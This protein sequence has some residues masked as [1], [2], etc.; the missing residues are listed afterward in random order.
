MK[1]QITFLAFAATTL[2][3]AGCQDDT[4]V[5][6]ADL[7]P[8][9]STA[10]GQ[11]SGRA[12][13]ADHFI[14][15]YAGREVPAAAADLISAKGGQ[16]ARAWDGMGFA[17]ITEI[18]DDD[19]RE[20]LTVPG[21]TG[22]SRDVR[23]RWIPEVTGPQVRTLK[24]PGPKSHDPTDA[25]FFDAFQ[26]NMRQVEAD[27]AWGAGFEASPDV[28]VAV[29]DTGV[30]PDHIDLQGRVDLN[31]SR[32]VLID[33]FC[34]DF[35]DVPDRETFLDFNFHGTHVSGIVTTNGIGVAGVAPHAT[36]VAVKV[37]ACDGF[38]FFSQ[39]IDGILYAASIPVDV[40]N[41]SLG[42]FL[43]EEFEEEFEFESEFEEFEEEFEF[44]DQVLIQAF[45]AATTAAGDAGAYVVASAGND[46][47]DLDDL[48]F[49][50]ESESQFNG[51]ESQLTT[52]F[53]LK[54]VPAQS[55]GVAAIS[56]TGPIGQT[57][58][59]RLASY[60]NFGDGEISLAAPGGDF[61]LG[62]SRDFVLSTCSSKSVILPFFGID[63]SSGA[64]YLFLVGTSMSAPLVSGAGALL[65]SQFGGSLD[66]DEIGD[67]LE[68]TADRVGPS[69]THG[70]GRLN[71][72]RALTAGR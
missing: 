51:A 67:I 20:L 54:L 69:E 28:L 35:F 47:L 68:D 13:F 9:F 53:E 60:S 27:D 63:C 23:I 41:M 50:F 17:M 49:E 34:N 55:E 45:D 21:V 8:S 40:I 14:L 57:D 26:W 59:D 6:P 4:P 29:L 30:D 7:S 2:F 36:V 42:G 15:R 37:L 46:Q 71:V 58:F 33:P 61:L 72:F 44:D 52:T 10:S 22:V 12:G 39:I 48:E 56:A 18:N 11:A 62:D 3:L 1:R 65:D 16:I 43:V 19:A 38:G 70:A 32:S 24:Q 31:L 64:S 25:V 66:G 5:A